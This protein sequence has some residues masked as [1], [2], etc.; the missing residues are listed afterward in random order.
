MAERLVVFE[1]DSLLRLLTYYS[2]G[3]VPLTAKVL[4]VQTSR[5]LERMIRI[6][7]ESPEWAPSDTGVPI[8]IR[9]EAVR[10]RRMVKWDEKGTPI[11]WEET[12]DAPKR[13]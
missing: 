9:Y 6:E 1:P 4:S 3:K 8:E 11:E 12:P 5:L 7:V 10:S 2:D 13:S